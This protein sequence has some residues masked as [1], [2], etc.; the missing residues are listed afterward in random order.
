VGDA[1]RVTV[2]ATGFDD[3]A[4]ARAESYSPREEPR[5]RPAAR[6][7]ET[8]EPVRLEREDREQFSL[9]DEA[10]DIPDFLK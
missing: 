4:A 5:P 8:R 6:P 9:P 2:I 10:L 7:A 3:S 1:V